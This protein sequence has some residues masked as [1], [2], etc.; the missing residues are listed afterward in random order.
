M[1]KSTYRIVVRSVGKNVFPIDMLRYDDCRPER[2]IDSHLIRESMNHLIEPTEEVYLR[3]LMDGDKYTNQ[4]RW[5][6]FGWTV[7]RVEKYA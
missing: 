6:S 7:V 5:E 3:K 1:K 2:E 4:A